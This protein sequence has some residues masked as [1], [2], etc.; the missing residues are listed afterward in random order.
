MQ[1][2]KHSQELLNMSWISADTAIK[3]KTIPYVI[4]GTPWQVIGADIFKRKNR[5]ILC[6]VH[7][8]IKFPM[9][10]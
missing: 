6:V 5:N 2:W 4:P 9:V 1:R 10:K 7:Y 3:K 8:H